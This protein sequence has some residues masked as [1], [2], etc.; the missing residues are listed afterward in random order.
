MNAKQLAL[1]HAAMV[2][3]LMDHL[4]AVADTIPRLRQAAAM[5]HYSDAEL[6]EIAKRRNNH[7]LDRIRRHARL[8]FACA[9]LHLRDTDPSFWSYR[10][11]LTN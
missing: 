10:H 8:A 2:R 9:R 6:L 3:R 4:P 7:R 11:L 1:E 5:S